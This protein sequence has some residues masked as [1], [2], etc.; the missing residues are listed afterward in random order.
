MVCILPVIFSKAF[1][2]NFVTTHRFTVIATHFK[3]LL[4]CMNTILAGFSFTA[5][6]VHFGAQ[7]SIAA[8]KFLKLAFSF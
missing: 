4:K 5:K 7:F 1:Q 6:V 8:P 2:A 3:D